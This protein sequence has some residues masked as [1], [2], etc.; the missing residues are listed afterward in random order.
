VSFYTYMLR[1][2][3]GSFYVGHTDN[4]EARI[5]QHHLGMTD[6]YTSSRLPVELVWSS[7]FPT[8]YEALTAERQ[9]KG[10]SRAKKQALIRN[11]WAAISRL[12]AVVLR[13]AQDERVSGVSRVQKRKVCLGQRTE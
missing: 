13:Q 9:L 2:S 5:V 1:C 7:D 8:R 4:I 12:P 10:W 11:D 6:G 3:D